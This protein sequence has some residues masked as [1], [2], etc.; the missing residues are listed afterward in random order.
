MIRKSISELLRL[1]KPDGT[2]DYHDWTKD[3]KVIYSPFVPEVYTNP[4]DQRVLTTSRRLFVLFKYWAL[5]KVT[6]VEEAKKSIPLCKVCQK[7]LA[8][9]R[10]TEPKDAGDDWIVSCRCLECSKKYNA[11]KT[12][13]GTYR[14]HGV[15]NVSS[16]NLMK[17]IKSQIQRKNHAERGDE[18]TAKRV[19]TVRERHGKDNVSQLDWVKNQKAETFMKHF[20]VSNIFKRIDLMK[21][22]WLDALGVEHPRYDMEIHQKCCKKAIY[23]MCRSS[24][25][26]VFKIQ[27]KEFGVLAPNEAYILRYLS[28]VIPPEM[29]ESNETMFSKMIDKTPHCYTIDVSINNIFFLE[30]KSCRSFKMNMDNSSYI[31]ERLKIMHGQLKPGQYYLF[32]VRDI[33]NQHLAI[34]NYNFTD[35]KIISTVELDDNHVSIKNL[36][37]D[38][39]YNHSKQFYGKC[40]MDL[41]LRN[42]I[43]KKLIEINALVNDSNNWGKDEPQNYTP[44]VRDLTY[45]TKPY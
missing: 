30:M 36:F 4:E 14:K 31:I 12:A 23:A 34:F 9:P 24:Q 45:E 39:I 16:L 40:N 19:N 27:E 28:K 25:G 8:L 33:S 38:Y 32:Y 26:R 29:L 35:I 10:C 13:E 21:K 22:Y 42:I 7:E 37:G 43:Y 2:S 6:S 17:L 11:L 15:R 18:I 20:G 5:N 41:V 1:V 44:N 3:I